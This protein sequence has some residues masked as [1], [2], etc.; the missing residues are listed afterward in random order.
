[1][2][3]G[4]S[5]GLQAVKPGIIASENR[6][7]AAAAASKREILKQMHAYHTSSSPET[8]TEKKL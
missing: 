6:F 2:Q 5:M 1:M 4:I 8:L 7:A 3:I